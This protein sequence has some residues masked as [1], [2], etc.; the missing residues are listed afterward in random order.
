MSYSSLTCPRCGSTDVHARPKLGDHTCHECGHCWVSGGNAGIDACIPAP[1]PSSLFSGCAS[2]VGQQSLE[3]DLALA[4]EIQTGFLPT[5]PPVV[6]GYDFYDFYLP[7][8]CDGGGDY[9]D[10]IRLLDDRIAIVVSHV[11][12]RGIRAGTLKGLLGDAIKCSLALEADPGKAVTHLN[13]RMYS[14]QNDQLLVT[15]LLVVL[16]PIKHQAA[17][18]SAGHMAPIW[19]R[20]DGQVGEPGSESIGFPLA[21]I[22]G[23]RYELTTIALGAG[24]SLTLF[25][26]GLNA[27]L[28]PLREQYTL[29]RLR[30]VIQ[31]ASSDVQRIGRAIVDDVTGFKAGEVQTNDWC[32]VCVGR[33][34]D[35]E[36]R[37][38][39][40]NPG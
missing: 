19:R 40:Q 6:P 8:N 4:R 20:S 37:R 24:E 10:Y 38:R 5:S 30:N 11:L 12:G 23:H 17:I 29:D 35:P 15:A 22:E 2:P 18:V 16:D 26:D 36:D 33:G 25:T 27:T 9:F 34:H 13:A 39:T 1:V 21:V 31:R 7:A 32:I 3:H 28:N 14:R